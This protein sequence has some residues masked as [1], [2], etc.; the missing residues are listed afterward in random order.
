MNDFTTK[1]DV[2]QGL[3]LRDVKNGRERRWREKKI[4]TLV[5]ADA[6]KRLGYDSRAERVK[7]CGTFLEF[8]VN[9][10]NGEKFL[11][12]ANFCKAPL[13]PMCQ[14]RK[15]LKV[16]YEVG[17]VMDEVQA[18]Y[19][20]LTPLFL[21][22]TVKNCAVD[23]L[24]TAL[25]TIVKGFYNFSH[26]RK[27]KSIV[28]GFF[29]ALEITYN[30]ETDEFHPH[31]HAILLVDKQYFKSADYMTTD[32][33]RHIWERSARLDYFARVD[34]R[35]VKTINGT[36]R[37][38]KRKEIAEVAKYTLK[39]TDF[40]YSMDDKLTDKLVGALSS[41]LHHRRLFAFGGV[42]KDVAKE[43]GADEPDEGDLV[44]IDE[45]TVRPDLSDMII[46][47]NWK[48]GIANYVRV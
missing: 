27:V 9:L 25:N 37:T 4:R 36:N 34:V 41:G 18:R 31:I 11:Q 47:Y 10:E 28:K 46:R 48:F 33:W 19:P 26:D 14:W 16:G 39:D 24:K 42:M 17:R 45:K 21:T 20:D 6:L 38:T 3:I 1:K 15:S 12:S 13:C 32:D 43:I 2:M 5:L 7:Y 44:H 35:K 23:E 22:L 40:L 29:R 30:R 8:L